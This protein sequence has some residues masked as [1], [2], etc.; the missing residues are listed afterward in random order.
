MVVVY[1]LFGG[2]MFGALS[3]N[4]QEFSKHSNGNASYQLM[5]IDPCPPGLRATG[6]A[7]SL[8]ETVL[9]KQRN[10]DGT[11]GEVCEAEPTQ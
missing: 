6:Y 7:L 11:V 4:Y 5:F 9:L 3:D 10:I 1:L 8:N 2:L